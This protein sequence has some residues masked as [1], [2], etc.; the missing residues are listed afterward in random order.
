[1]AAGLSAELPELIWS[2][3][4]PPLEACAQLESLGQW[5]RR[6][7]I[8]AEDARNHVA[9]LWDLAS[10]QASERRSGAVDPG[11]EFVPLGGGGVEHLTGA[12]HNPLF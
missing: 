9:L 8:A 2:E 1:M 7:E 12:A 4:P 3:P 10:A 11:Q 6:L 5:L